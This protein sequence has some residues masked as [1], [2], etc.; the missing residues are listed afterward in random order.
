MKGGGI[1]EH[2][3]TKIARFHD[4]SGTGNSLHIARTLASRLES[5]GFLIEFF[6]VSAAISRKLLSSGGDTAARGEGDLDLFMFPVF[7]MS[8]P[9]IMA[10]YISALGP[11]PRGR[12]GSGGGAR[13]RAA[14][15][16]ANGRVS[17]KFRDGHE[18]QALA[19]A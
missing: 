4:F 13:P 5:S 9:R 8:M 11:R 10:R 3:A 17:D 14:I 16:C 6:E 19:Q 15:L 12:S 2:G 18:G 7:A 1:P